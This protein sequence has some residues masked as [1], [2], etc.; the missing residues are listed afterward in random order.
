MV[1]PW[2]T[3]QVRVRRTSDNAI[4][5]TVTAAEITF[6]TAANTIYVVERTAKPLTG[7]TRDAR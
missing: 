4:L 5:T 6:A 7:Y 2:G 3:Q 1:N